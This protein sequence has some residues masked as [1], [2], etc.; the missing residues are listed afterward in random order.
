MTGGYFSLDL[1]GECLWKMEERR[2][3]FIKRGGGRI[4]Q[5]Q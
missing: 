5:E 2:I 1:A 4:E 3:F